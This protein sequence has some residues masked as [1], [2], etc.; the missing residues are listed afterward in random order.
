MSW[1]AGGSAEQT[2]SNSQPRIDSRVSERAEI[3]WVKV[4]GRGEVMFLSVRRKED[5]V[6]DYEEEYS[7]F[8]EEEEEDIVWSLTL[9]TV[10]KSMGG[11]YQCEVRCGFRKSKSPVKIK[12]C[13]L[14]RF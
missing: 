5:G 3:A 11:L 4:L 10:D 7:S 2:N 13:L 14:E 1:S 8:Y 6:I 12:F 9:H